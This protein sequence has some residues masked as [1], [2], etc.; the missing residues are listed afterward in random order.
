MREIRNMDLDWRFHLGE[1]P[2]AYYMGYDDRAWRRVTLPH[3]WAV[4]H[5]FDRCHSSGTGYLPGGIGWYRKRF[6]LTE[7]DAGKRVV[8]TFQGVI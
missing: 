7:E 2:D 3:D 1:A 6:L 4:E 8:L 5:P